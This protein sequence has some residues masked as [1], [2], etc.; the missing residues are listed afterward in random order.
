MEGFTAGCGLSNC[1]CGVGAAHPPL[2]NIARKAANAFIAARREATVDRSTHRSSD[3]YADSSI[4]IDGNPAG[5]TG[6]LLDLPAYTIRRS[7]RARRSRITI[8]QQ[9]EAVVVL[10]MRAPEQDAADLVARYREWVLRNIGRMAARRAALGARPSIDSGRELLYL[11]V[12]HRVV[13]LA[14]TDGR[15]RPSV[16]VSDGRIVV[17]SALG[18]GRPT[19][20]IL[21]AWFRSQ[22]KRQIAARVAARAPDLGVAP[23]SVT[24]RDQKSRWGSASPRGTL[25]FSWRLMMCPPEVLE[26]VVIHELA[27][28]KISGHAPSFWRLVARHYPDVGGARRW[29]R[30]HHH[31]IRH[32]LD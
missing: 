29:L 10:P 31:E 27:H 2:T 30:A 22:A 1:N 24:I 4:G 13:S 23:K 25:S 8:T 7:A 12:H 17:T 3:S 26:Y 5:V 15:A 21:D 20:V 19:S 9:A 6:T 28:M 14:A 11:G 32:A 18:N 16:R